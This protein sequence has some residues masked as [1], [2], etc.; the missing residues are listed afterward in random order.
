ME[1]KKIVVAGGGVLGSQIAFQTAFCGFDVHVWLRSEASIERAKPK[2]LNLKNTYLNTLEDMKTNPLAYCRGFTSKKALSNEE[3]EELKKDVEKAFDRLVLSTSFEEVSKD[4][5]LVIESIAENPQEK[6]D[7]YTELAKYLPEKTIVVTNSS[8][9]MPSVF[10]KYTGREEKYLALHF[11]NSIW[12]NNTAE[13]MGHPKTSEEFYEQVV[14]FAEAIRMIPLKLKK[15]QPGYILNTMLVPFLEAAEFLVANEV[16]DPET[17]DKTWVLG[18]GAPM[19]P[20]RI[21][22]IIGLTTAYNVVMLHPDAKNPETP[23]GKIAVMLKKY[24]DEGKTGIAVGE[25]FY[26]YS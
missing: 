21:L 25:G 12:K 17:V 2:F 9:M 15:E 19:G 1:F 3:I 8:T 6:I 24:I 11:A 26:K 10:A 20:F 4:A 5:D 14:A 7:F 16:A 23:K 13:I 18:T 22:D